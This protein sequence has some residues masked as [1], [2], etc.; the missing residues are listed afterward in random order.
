MNKYQQYRKDN[1][2]C[3]D[4]AEIAAPGKTRCVKCLRNIAEKQRMRYQ[5]GG[6]A[7]RQARRK[8]EK[9]WADKNREHVREYHRKWYE[10]NYKSVGE[11][12]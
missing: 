3:I 11:D 7:Y 5:D 8:Y 12:I 2:L 4:C 10:E 9:K 6:E 1:G